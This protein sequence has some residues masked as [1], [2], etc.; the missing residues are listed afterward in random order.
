M[1]KK[2]IWISGIAL[3]GVLYFSFAMKE[4]SISVQ[5]VK[6]SKSNIANYI[7]EDA[8]T[9]L[10]K[11]HII[12]TTI[13]GIILPNEFKEGDFI[14]QG[15]IIAKFDNY[16]RNEKLS[17]FKSK[18]LELNEMIE[19][20]K[21][22]RT[23]QEEIETS[24][25]RVKQSK[26]NLEEISKQKKLLELN[27]NQSKNDYIRTKKLL[28]QQAINKSDFEKV[29]TNYNSSKINL[30]NIKNQEILALDNLKISELSLNK[31]IKSVN[32]NDYQR[33]VYLEQ[34]NQ[35]KNEINILD[36][37]L[38]K[39]SIK[40][41]FSGPVL[42][43]YL[44]DKTA[45]PS[46]SK[47]LKIGDL[48]S[49]AIESDILSEE[50]PQIKVG[51]TVEISGKALDNK[52]IFGKVSRIY[53]I[54]FTK[55]SALGVEQQRVKIISYFDNKKI[56][57]RPETSLDI[58]II[59][60][61]HKNVLTIPE[62]SMFKEKDKWF[63][64]IVNNENKLELKEI[65]VGLKNEDNAEVLSGVSENQTIVLEPDNTLKEGQ[66]VKI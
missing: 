50:V 34:I 27:F 40:S 37:E 8:K 13:D 64:F 54:G 46:G 7:P 39:T 32:D 35:L 18:L 49:I 62:R 31:I 41:E 21:V 65:K 6:V 24:K 4:S 59:T 38:S 1:N 16:N 11:E 47:I 58:K 44:K 60:Q 2:V 26:T 3:L 23:K 36:K 45:L 52:K 51:M 53:P 12:Y 19:G 42:E 56:N 43:I 29:E 57:L 10:E 61:E 33:R 63:V 28:E 15:Q 48:N 17:S 55:I 20:V 30:Q 66:K 5:T 25:L 9:I 22:V 14:Q